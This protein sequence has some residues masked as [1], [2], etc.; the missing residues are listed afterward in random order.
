MIRGG[1]LDVGV[2]G[3][4]LKGGLGLHGG[5][6]ALFGAGAQNVVQ[7]TMVNADGD[8]ITV[9]E[10]GMSIRKEGKTKVLHLL[11]FVTFL[12]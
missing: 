4:L 11:Y 2:G 12:Q 1:C 10:K 7:Y 5:S 8:I 9:N 6:S 3:F